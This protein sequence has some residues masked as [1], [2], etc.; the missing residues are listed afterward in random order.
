MEIL[1]IGGAIVALMIYTSTR[2]KRNAAAAFAEEAVE[3]DEFSLVKPEGFLAPV[4]NEDFLAFYAYSKDFGDEGK[5]EKMRQSLIKLKIL[6]GRSPAEIAKDIKSKFNA[7]LR[8]EKHVADTI[9]L[10]GART[11]NEV[12]TLYYHKLVAQGEKVFDLEMAVLSDYQEAY[13]ER[14]EKLLMSF[15]VK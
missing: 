9:L 4:E 6:A 1:I 12:E 2:I 14:A 7:T 15:R 11:E 3:T 8:E 5:A 10:T 13:E